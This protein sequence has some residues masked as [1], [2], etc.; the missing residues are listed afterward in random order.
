MS[1]VLRFTTKVLDEQAWGADR[2]TPVMP[3][4]GGRWR[5]GEAGSWRLV[6]FG[7]TQHAEGPTLSR[8]IGDRLRVEAGVWLL[9]W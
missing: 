3:A 2:D 1:R 6:Q 8:F 4:A 9:S 7:G 5:L